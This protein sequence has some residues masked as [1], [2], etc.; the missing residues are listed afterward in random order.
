M[1]MSPSRN[2]AQSAAKVLDARYTSRL[3]ASPEKLAGLRHEVVE[4][5]L[6]VARPGLRAYELDPPRLRMGLYRTILAE[7]QHE[8][9]VTL[10]NCDL[11]LAEWP[12]LRTPVSRHVQQVREEAFPDLAGAGSVAA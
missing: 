3:P 9:L 10:R 2:A 11:P 8:D 6:H 1:T 5:P 12:V 7:G 4:L